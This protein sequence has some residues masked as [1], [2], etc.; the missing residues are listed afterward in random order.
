MSC[1]EYVKLTTTQPFLL[2][3]R[4]KAKIGWCLFSSHCSG[5][6]HFT[7]I[8]ICVF[9][10]VIKNFFVSHIVQQ[11]SFPN[12]FQVL[13]PLLLMWTTVLN[14]NVCAQDLFLVRHLYDILVILYILSVYYRNL[15]VFIYFVFFKKTQPSLSLFQTLPLNLITLYIFRHICTMHIWIEFP[16]HVCSFSSRDYSVKH[17]VTAKR[18]FRAVS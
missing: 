9:Q 17:T 11:Y 10:A 12:E 3:V 4:T 16:K 7:A 15:F 2:I 6:I 18:S 8:I 13:V 1:L 5:I 14:C